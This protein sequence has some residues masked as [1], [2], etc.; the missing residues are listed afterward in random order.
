MFACLYNKVSTFILVKIIFIIQYSC[1]KINQAFSL[2]FFPATTCIK[3]PFYLSE[4]L[5]SFLKTSNAFLTWGFNSNILSHSKVTSFPLLL[6]SF[7]TS[8]LQTPTN[9]LLIFHIDITSCKMCFSFLNWL[10]RLVFCCCCCC[11]VFLFF[12]F[13][14]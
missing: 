9:T 5:E 14:Y 13:F 11:C 12:W 3:P 10:L 8:S 4:P 7:N 6:A 2:K 1:H